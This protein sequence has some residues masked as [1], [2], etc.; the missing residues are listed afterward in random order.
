M[1]ATKVYG[2]LFWVCRIESISYRIYTLKQSPEAESLGYTVEAL[3]RAEVGLRKETQTRSRDLRHHSERTECVSMSRS[4]RELWVYALHTV[5]PNGTMPDSNLS[6]GGVEAVA[7]TTAQG[8]FLPPFTAASSSIS[9]DQ[10][11]ARHGPLL[12]AIEL[13]MLDSL[14][15]NG[16]LSQ[17][18]AFGSAAALSTGE[19][20]LVRVSPS[21]Y[22]QGGLLMRITMQR[23]LLVPPPLQS[24]Q[25]S[26][27]V[28]WLLP[29]GRPC[30][31][32]QRND[33]DSRVEPPNRRRA[34]QLF[35]LLNGQFVMNA[36]CADLENSFWM[37]VTS[38]ADGMELIWPVV[39]IRSAPLT[40]TS[41]LSN[42]IAHTWNAQHHPTSRSAIFENHED[43]T[44]S[45]N[46]DR[47]GAIQAHL[48]IHAIYPHRVPLS[49]LV[50]ESPY[51]MLTESMS[52]VQQQLDTSKPEGEWSTATSNTLNQPVLPPPPSPRTGITRVSSEVNWH[53]SPGPTALQRLQPASSLHAAAQSAQSAQPSAPP[54]AD[55][56]SQIYPTPNYQT[57]NSQTPHHHTPNYQTPNY[58]TPAYATPSAPLPPNEAWMDLA[59]E[60][61]DAEAVDDA[62]FNF[63]DLPMPGSSHLEQQPQLALPPKLEINDE[64]PQAS[65]DHMDFDP[66]EKTSF[67]P[68]KQ[69]KPA[70]PRTKF[71]VLDVDTSSLDAKYQVGGRFYMTAPKD[72]SDEMD[73]INGTSEGTDSDLSSSDDHISVNSSDLDMDFGESMW[74]Q[75]DTSADHTHTPGHTRD[76]DFRYQSPALDTSL[77]QHSDM[78]V[79][80]LRAIC[81]EQSYGL[82][83]DNTK[84]MT[85]RKLIRQLVWDG[86][87]LREMYDA[88]LFEGETYVPPDY[89]L[90]RLGLPLK[91][92]PICFNPEYFEG[93]SDS[94]KT[95]QKHSKLQ[96]LSPPFVQV[97]YGEQQ[98]KARIAILNFWRLLNLAPPVK[99]AQDS[100]EKSLVTVIMVTI[101]SPA[102]ADAAR[103]FL[104]DFQSTYEHCRL[105]QVDLPS[106]GDVKNG[107]LLINADLSRLSGDSVGDLYESTLSVLKAQIRS[108][109]QNSTPPENLLF[110]VSYPPSSLRGG[111]VTAAA[112]F[113]I[114]QGI[115]AIRRDYPHVEWM[116]SCLDMLVNRWDHAQVISAFRM[117]KVSLLTY[118]R[119]RKFPQP[120]QLVGLAP[121]SS[122][123]QFTPDVPAVLME[124]EDFLHVAYLLIGNRWCLTSWTD[125][126]ARKVSVD[127]FRV[128]DVSERGMHNVFLDIWRRSQEIAGNIRNR[129]GWRFVITRCGMMNGKELSI[130]ERVIPDDISVLFMDVPQPRGVRITDARSVKRPHSAPKEG[131][132][133]DSEG[134]QANAAYTQ[135]PLAENQR[136]QPPTSASTSQSGTPSSRNSPSVAPSDGVILNEACEI[137]GICVEPLQPG[138]GKCAPSLSR[139]Y[140]VIPDLEGHLSLETRL[141][142][143]KNMKIT[144]KLAMSRI[145]GQFRRLASICEY[146]GVSTHCTLI[147]WHILGLTK[148]ETAAQKLNM[149]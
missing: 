114:A 53:H 134:Q 143:L 146:S 115:E 77:Q 43:D 42:T 19:G 123:L 64:P 89:V 38:I 34:R 74:D 121:Q 4:G 85:F 140:L 18:E 138:V 65:P 109:Y 1:D 59:N 136:P 94:D 69:S 108:G 127:V 79:K 131:V 37:R 5:P 56:P 75:E 27:S 149:L 139:G 54:A 110:L 112:P 49:A 106:F 66:E 99:E 57:P 3:R 35:A 17:Y 130:W 113:Q 122:G 21:L 44:Q 61:N 148:L 60:E 40:T 100:P 12:R 87:L 92:L 144:S 117:Q 91:H 73:D 20:S 72:D 45:D 97:R 25:F 29:Q 32:S 36:S 52:S 116:L 105:G 119:F 124:D 70:D 145:I 103:E 88:P 125:Q 90:Q 84:F 28:V 71:D 83:V 96:L 10:L 62:D 81:N 137:Y 50:K 15:R 82:P 86:G 9:T 8:V 142:Y 68:V 128:K 48:S 80:W 95:P 76:T 39:L 58:S 24:M 129:V 107:L 41:S 104:V 98:I 14:L 47:I 63:F 102:I 93:V 67:S 6:F 7:D 33:V 78:E 126:W 26:S 118:S 11:E 23:T 51:T 13:Y 141:L 101:D 31:L 30:R 132:P 55:T 2:E 147:P 135:A 111:T 46:I 133:T 120:F 16:D 22:Q